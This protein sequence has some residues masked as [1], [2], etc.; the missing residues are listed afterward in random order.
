MAKKKSEW[1]KM[2]ECGKWLEDFLA[3]RL[4]N[5]DLKRL[6]RQAISIIDLE[7]NFSENHILFTHLDYLTKKQLNWM[8]DEGFSLLFDEKEKVDNQTIRSL[9]MLQNIRRY[10]NELLKEFSKNKKPWNITYCEMQ[11]EADKLFGKNS[12]LE[13]SLVRVLKIMG[14]N[15][16]KD[17]ANADPLTREEI[18]YLTTGSL[19]S[20]FRAIAD[21]FNQI[22]E[23]IIITHDGYKKVRAPLECSNGKV[24]P[25]F[26]TNDRGQLFFD[27]IAVKI[28]FDFLFSNGQDYYGY[29]DYCEKFYVAERKGRKKFCSDVCRTMNQ[30]K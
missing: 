9:M 30:R 17:C 25:V 29:C 5:W 12:D 26:Y 18:E 28:F 6:F 10:F 21:L 15:D 22:G 24:T 27:A 19:I 2:V 20:S 7:Y 13:G 11:K 23:T 8:T 3:P 14:K 4:E 16:Q 1:A